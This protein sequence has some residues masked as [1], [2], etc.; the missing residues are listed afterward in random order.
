[1]I[2][3]DNSGPLVQGFDHRPVIADLKWA[4]S[5]F[6]CPPIARSLRGW[7]PCTEEQLECFRAACTTPSV[8]Q[9]TLDNIE[10]TMA[11]LAKSIDFHAKGKHARTPNQEQD[12]ELH[13][14]KELFRA[15]IGVDRKTCM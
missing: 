7:S 5:R 3:N 12:Q 1:M 4:H 2:A 11:A 10:E 6:S 14:A 15:A 13:V 9:S 8:L